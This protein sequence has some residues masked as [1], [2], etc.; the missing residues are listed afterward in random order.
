ML[1]LFDEIKLVIHFITM[2]KGGYET[3]FGLY[4]VIPNTTRSILINDYATMIKD[5]ITNRT[6]D[7]GSLRLSDEV[8]FFKNGK[9]ID[10]SG[11]SPYW[12]SGDYSTGRWS[13]EDD[14]LMKTRDS[15]ERINPGY[16]DTEGWKEFRQ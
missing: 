10:P 14:I 9:N 4:D 7:I 5:P 6:S 16:V 1:K 3:Q 12:R 8:K 13:E 2:S 15:T 11:H